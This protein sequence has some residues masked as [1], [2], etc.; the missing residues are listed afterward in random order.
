ML[1]SDAFC[2]VRGY[3]VKTES[4]VAEDFRYAVSFNSCFSQQRGL[5]CIDIDKRELICGILPPLL[6]NSSGEASFKTF[7]K[8]FRDSKL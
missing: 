2:I 4:E 8:Q 7:F 6:I 1:H 3:D 5:R